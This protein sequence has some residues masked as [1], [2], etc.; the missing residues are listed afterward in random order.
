[1]KPR[2]RRDSGAVDRFRVRLDQILDR[3]HTLVKLGRQLDWRFWAERFRAIY[4][5]G[6]GQK[7]LSDTANVGALYAQKLLGSL[8]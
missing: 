8:R 4:A 5:D 2:K 6:P 7:P 3:N 1:M